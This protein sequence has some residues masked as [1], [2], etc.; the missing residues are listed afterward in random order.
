MSC[1]AKTL[2]AASN[3][4]ASLDVKQLQAIN[5]YLLCQILANGVG[6]GAPT[7]IAYA[8]PPLTNPPALANLVI[9]TNKNVWGYANGTWSL[10]V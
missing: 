7:S 2:A 5:A 3:C 6:G 4:L 9:D 1:D 10:I 8:G